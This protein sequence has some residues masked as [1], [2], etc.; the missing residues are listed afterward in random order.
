MMP[1]SK[2]MKYQP[3]FHFRSESPHVPS[4]APPIKQAL[5]SGL[6]L[7]SFSSFVVGLKAYTA[8]VDTVRNKARRIRMLRFT[9]LPLLQIRIVRCIVIQRIYLWGQMFG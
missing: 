9:G 5:A 3:A 8:R 7:G 4:H 2:R 1:S 6:I